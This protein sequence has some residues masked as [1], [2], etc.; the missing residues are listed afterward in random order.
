MENSYEPLNCTKAG[1]ECKGKVK[2]I[3]SYVE[4]DSIAM[5]CGFEQGDELLC[6]N[7]C[8]IEDILDYR[9]LI[10][11]EYLVLKV[12]TKQGEIVEVEI[13]KEFD[14]DLGLEFENSFMDNFKSC[15]NKCIFC[16]I[17]QLPSNMRK[18]LYFKDD[19]SRL[20]FLQG[21]YCTLTNLSEKDVDR[22]IRYRLEPVNISFQTMNKELRCKMLGN[23][24]AGDALK[25]VD[26]FYDAGITMN[27]QIVL[28]KGINDGAELEYSLEEIYKYMPYVDSLSIVPVG[29]SDYRKGLYP[30]E[31]FDREDAL[32]VIETVEKWQKKAMKD[33]GYHFV[34]ASDEW[35]LLAGLPMPSATTYDG[36]LQIENGVGMITS[37]KDEAF[38]TI[39][40]YKDCNIKGG[41][42]V[43]VACGIAPFDMMRE[44]ADKIKEVF[45]INLNICPVVNDFFGHNI[46][47]TGLITGGDIIKQLKGQNLG[48]S[49]MIASCSVKADEPIFLDDV[50]V[51][52][53]ADAL[54]VKVDI[55]KSNGIDF[56]KYI[57]K[58]D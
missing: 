49:L 53:V 30:L 13:E 17:D 43:S 54:Q 40:E 24:F 7:D 58:Q 55:V 31:P 5:E 4:E 41:Y 18:T 16:F 25:I 50:S 34:H 33:Y 56:V 23:R 52:E 11:D 47:V 1:L 22:I 27:G 19:D 36:Y 42:T 39:D 38:E 48:E 29:L 26:R 12:R 37:F 44:I 8:E 57:L 6:I 45:D 14:D 15:K 20:S 10:K 9:F 2:H 3:V 46:T 21:N 28:C 51:G 35:Y 32:S